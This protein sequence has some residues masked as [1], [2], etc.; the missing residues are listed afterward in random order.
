MFTIGQLLVIFN[1]ITDQEGIN[2]N[3][4]DLLQQVRSI[5]SLLPILEPIA[6]QFF[7]VGL[8]IYLSLKF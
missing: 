6:N 8:S 1:A 7:C 5:P 4:I 2:F 3:K